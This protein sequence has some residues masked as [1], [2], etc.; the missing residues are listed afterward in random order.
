MFKFR[1]IFSNF[2]GAHIEDLT[3]IIFE[4]KDDEMI[5]NDQWLSI[6]QLKGMINLNDESDENS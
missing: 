5:T 4:T 3:K 2:F 1:P 6:D